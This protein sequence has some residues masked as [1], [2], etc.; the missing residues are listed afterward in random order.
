VKVDP[1]EFQGLS[2]AVKIKCPCESVFRV[3]LGL[4][5]V[6]RKNSFLRGYYFKLPEGKERGRMRVRDVSMGGI[7]FT[8]WNEHALQVGDTIRVQFVLD[9]DGNALIEKIATV[10]WINNAA[11]GCQF[12]G[13]KPRDPDLGFYFVEELPLDL[14]LDRE[15]SQGSTAQG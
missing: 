1:A 11:V 12:N 4:R 10:R 3:C 2:N 15:V 7:Q 6:Q 8:S 14:S 9:N 13:E 5:K